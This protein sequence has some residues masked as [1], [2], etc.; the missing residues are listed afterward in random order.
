[1]SNGSLCELRC[2]TICWTLA[3]QRLQIVRQGEQA[4]VSTQ[5]ASCLVNSFVQGFGT[6][7]PNAQATVLVVTGCSKRSHHIKHIRSA[8]LQTYLRTFQGFE[9]AAQ[10][11]FVTLKLV[12][13]VV[14]PS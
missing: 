12:N 9:S 6:R 11:P 3:L 2:A 8:S 10:Q 1:M 13:L 5:T 4:Y 14:G 7:R